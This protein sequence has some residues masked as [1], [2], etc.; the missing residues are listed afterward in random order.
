MFFC[1]DIFGDVPKTLSA[2]RM[3]ALPDT[4]NFLETGILPYFGLSLFLSPPALHLT[5]VSPCLVTARPDEGHSIR[6]W[7]DVCSA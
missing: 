4:S 7:V 3:K 6:P 5:R 1:K 2:K